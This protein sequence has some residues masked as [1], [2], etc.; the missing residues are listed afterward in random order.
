MWPVVGDEFFCDLDRM[1][2]KRRAV[3]LS[4]LN[5]DV[6]N[7]EQQGI[8]VGRRELALAEQAL[9]VAQKLKLLLW[10]NGGHGLGVQ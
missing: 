5:A 10:I 2:H 9:E 1:D 3:V 4:V 7:R 6:R 8:F